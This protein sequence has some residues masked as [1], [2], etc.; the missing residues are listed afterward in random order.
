MENR[1]ACLRSCT[2][3]HNSHHRIWSKWGRS[4]I[5]NRIS[6]LYSDRWRAT[7]N[8]C[9]GQE[10]EL[11]NA[12]LIF[13][14]YVCSEVKTFSSLSQIF[15]RLYCIL[16]CKCS[17]HRYCVW[18]KCSG[19]WILSVIEICRSCSNQTAW[20]KANLASNLMIDRLEKEDLLSVGDTTVRQRWSCLRDVSK[21]LTFYRTLLFFLGAQIVHVQ[22][23]T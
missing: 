5:K 18:M 14:L 16:M 20:R 15:R 2:D 10:Y 17:G 4:R 12:C 13:Y 1:S 6:W 9:S 19:V 7:G 22:D 23:M 8:R 3:F 11:V 21:V